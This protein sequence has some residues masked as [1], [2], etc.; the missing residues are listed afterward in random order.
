MDTVQCIEKKYGTSH[1]KTATVGQMK[2][3]FPV[4]VIG[5][6]C[7]HT[8]FFCL[9]ARSGMIMTHEDGDEPVWA[10]V[11]WYRKKTAT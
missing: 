3:W 9:A 1:P 5:K 6:S 2:R 10:F 7:R 4:W 8:V 11:M